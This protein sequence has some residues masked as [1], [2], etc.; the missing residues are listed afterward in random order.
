MKKYSF[1]LLGLLFF[2]SLSTAAQT[3]MTDAV[4]PSRADLNSGRVYIFKPRN[5][6]SDKTDQ[7]DMTG[8]GAAVFTASNVADG[9]IESYK[10][11]Q[12][13][14]I[15]LIPANNKAGSFQLLFYPESEHIPYAATNENGEVSIYYPLNLFNAIRGLLEESFTAKKKVT[16]KVIQK[17]NGYREGTLVF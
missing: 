11:A 15:T 5:P 14:S 17:T 3:I 8:M 13:I 9:T 10:H 7:F 6:S 16:V 1:Y 12:K 4:T 2:V